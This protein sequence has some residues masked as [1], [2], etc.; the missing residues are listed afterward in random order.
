MFHCSNILKQQYGQLRGIPLSKS[1]KKTEIEAE[2][3]N[4]ISMLSSPEETKLFLSDLCTPAELASLADRWF[5]AKAVAEGLPYRKVQEITGVSTAT[6]TRVARHLNYGS[7]GYRT[8][9][10]RQSGNRK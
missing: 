1:S 7:G 4:T 9:L 10:A 8:M 2:L 5:V 3:F 6:I